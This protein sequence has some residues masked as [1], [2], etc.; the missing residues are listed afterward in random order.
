[1]NDPWGGGKSHGEGESPLG[2]GAG[3]LTEDGQLVSSGGDVAA[4]VAVPGQSQL[5]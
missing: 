3:G 1:M 4:Q 2:E 5:V